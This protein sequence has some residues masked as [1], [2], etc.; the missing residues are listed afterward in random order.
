PPHTPPPVTTITCP[1]DRAHNPP[2]CSGTIVGPM[3][4]ARRANG[5]PVTGGT[6]MTDTA[7]GWNG[8][9]ARPRKQI[10]YSDGPRAEQ[11]IADSAMPARVSQRVPVRDGA[12]RALR[13]TWVKTESGLRCHWSL[14]EN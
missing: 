10:L 11:E 5:Y 9:W 7:L 14:A 3:K 1:C 8:K 4:G 2:D 12:R 6:A 13:C